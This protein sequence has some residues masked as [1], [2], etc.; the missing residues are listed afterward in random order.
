MMNLVAFIVFGTLCLTL[1]L[2]LIFLDLPTDRVHKANMLSM[3]VMTA[4]IS[5]QNAIYYFS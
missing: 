2:L 4:I 1:L 5:T 3:L